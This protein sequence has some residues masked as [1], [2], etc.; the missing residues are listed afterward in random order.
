LRYPDLFLTLKVVAPIFWGRHF[1]ALDK[2]RR[3]QWHLR[4]VSMAHALLICA[5]SV[6]LLFDDTFVADPLFGYDYYSGSVYAVAC[7]YGRMH[8]SF[9]IYLD[10]E[11]Q[12][13]FYYY[14]NHR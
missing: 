8:G 11:C 2:P 6:P 9:E 4:I 5:L 1:N 13:Q 7:G 10:L 14:F 3:A 12:F